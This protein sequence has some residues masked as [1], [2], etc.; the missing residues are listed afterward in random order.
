M[1]TNIL[2]C[3]DYPQSSDNI[4]VSD[5]IMG[6]L[7]CSNKIINIY[8]NYTLNYGLFRPDVEVHFKNFPDSDKCGFAIVSENELISLKEELSLE[9]EVETLGEK[10]KKINIALVLN[11]PGIHEIE[12]DDQKELSDIFHKQ[13][14][15]K[16]VKTLQQHPWLTIR[17]D[18]INKCNLR[19]IMCHY[20][21]NEINSQPLKLLTADQLKHQLQDIA[22]YVKHIMLSCGF[23]PLMSK[24]FSEIILMLRQNYPHLEIGLC[25]NGM[26]LD[27]KIRK[28][29][30]ENNVTHIIFSF[31]G[32]T[33]NTLEN[34]R[35]G[36]NYNKIISNIKALRDL[37]RK[38]KRNFPLMFMD[39]VLMKSN[40]HEAP[41]FVKMC[42]DL[43]FEI[44][45][46]RHLVGNI[47]FKEHDQML[48]LEKERYN[49]YRQLIIDESKK[50]PIDVRLPEAFETDAGYTP[51]TLADV[52]LTDFNAVEADE[53]TLEVIPTPDIMLSGG[54][55][56]DFYFL[57]N[58]SCQ[59]PFNEIMIIDQEKIL[60]CSYYNDSMGKID[61]NNTLHS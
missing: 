19:C 2:Y 30:I 26:L 60:P 52:D 40:L 35:I 61:E 14:E 56:S 27:S 55:D 20:K 29:L 4:V 43:G 7:V 34:I 18:I 8:C 6:W 44:I 51:E 24:H 57:S 11:S 12:I 16:F 17:M 45:D 54:K 25:T 59:R 42:S 48:T 53:Q 5:K 10:S 49:Y 47:Y 33:K 31:D 32:V 37:K 39:F 3:I 46:F 1:I 38:H 15:E 41:A 28:I 36:A 23:E 13:V 22:P 50:Y 21:E 58:L 9:I